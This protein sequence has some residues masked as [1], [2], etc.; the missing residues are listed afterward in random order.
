[1]SQ[2][3]PSDVLAL[4]FQQ[5]TL[6]DFL[7][8]ATTCHA[9]HAAARK[10]AAWPKT[11]RIKFSPYFTHSLYS[12]PLKHTVWA[13][14]SCLAIEK[15]QFPHGWLWALALPHV[16]DLSVVCEPIHESF[17]LEACRPMF[18][19][20]TSLRTSSV[21]LAQAVSYNRLTCLTITTPCQGKDAWLNVLPKLTSL[22]YLKVDTCV[23]QRYDVSSKMLGHVLA[24]LIHSHHTLHTIHLPFYVTCK[25]IILDGLLSDPTLD[26]SSLRTLL[27][28]PLD[29]PTMCRVIRS[30]PCL[31]TYNGQSGKGHLNDLPLKDDDDNNEEPGIRSLT[32]EKYSRD[33]NPYLMSCLPRLTNLTVYSTVGVIG[34]SCVHL[35]RLYLPE[36]YMPHSFPHA[37]SFAPN[38]EQ[39]SIGETRDYLASYGLEILSRIPRLQHLELRNSNTWGDM[40]S[41]TRVLMTHMAQSLSWR[42]ITCEN[43]PSSFHLSRGTVLAP[44]L[45]FS[46]VRWH[47]LQD[48]R[49]T[50]T[51]R[52]RLRLSQ[53]RLWIRGLSTQRITWE[54][55]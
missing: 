53:W 54:R 50:H 55:V 27:G 47:V 20:L 26:L 40:E 51:Y 16:F 1:M 24:Q 36:L 7:S 14:C 17:I 39:L 19:R 8:A 44:S 48:E 32:L 11:V 2:E 10:R 5:L 49:V 6:V 33:L 29:T 35:R 15:D 18:A 21:V 41:F 38:L 46:L 42:H 4:I 31:S 9:W 45:P 25:N 28:V 43:M 3:T 12:R 23:H 52:P 37:Y 22:T 30:L 13:S 34:V